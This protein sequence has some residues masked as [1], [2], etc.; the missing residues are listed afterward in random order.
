MRYI[1]N[2][3]KTDWGT[4]YMFM[5]SKGRAFARAYIYDDDP[6]TII[7]DWLQVDE[8]S[9]NQGFG[10]WLQKVREELGRELGCKW[11][12]LWVVKGTWQRKWYKRRGYKYFGSFKE[13]KAV[14]LRKKL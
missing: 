7:L 12:M 1:R 9:R 10:T 8:D 2:K 6:K 5:E 13:N 11:S 14:W 4:V 3:S